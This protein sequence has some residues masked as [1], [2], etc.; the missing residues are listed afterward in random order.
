MSNTVV[1]KHND[2]NNNNDNH[3]GNIADS[4]DNKN[5]HNPNENYYR[6]SNIQD[7]PDSLLCHRKHTQS[8]NCDNVFTYKALTVEIKHHNNQVKNVRNMNNQI[9]NNLI[10]KLALVS[11]SKDNNPLMVDEGLV[12]AIQTATIT[13]NVIL[14]EG[15]KWKVFSR[16]KDPTNRA[17]WDSFID[18]PGYQ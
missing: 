10:D 17:V 11:L 5:T 18:A 2:N 4:N 1:T 14:F 8:N 9:D 15:K 16:H 7:P 6:H 3:V 13:F 12:Q